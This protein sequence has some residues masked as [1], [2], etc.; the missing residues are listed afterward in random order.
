MGWTTVSA[1]N[2]KKMKKKKGKKDVVRS[3]IITTLFND[4]EYTD[5][6]KSLKAAGISPSDTV[7]TPNDCQQW[8]Y[9]VARFFF[10]RQD[11]PNINGVGCYCDWIFDKA[12]DG[13]YEEKPVFHIRHTLSPKVVF[14]NKRYLKSLYHVVLAINSS[15]VL[16]LGNA[17][18]T[19]PVSLDKRYPQNM[20]I[21]AHAFETL[22]NKLNTLHT[23]IENPSG[24]FPRVSTLPVG[25][26]GHNNPDVR[27]NELLE[28]N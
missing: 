13:I 5:L 8:K 14:V 24:T 12:S 20:L 19:Y 2:N 23:F 9:H 26:P 22:I 1:S 4:S 11:H 27:A 3:S 15:F 21:S 16:I 18:M 7:L 10:L 17:D 6:A 25:L 28:G